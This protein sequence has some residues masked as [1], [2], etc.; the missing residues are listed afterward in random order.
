MQ[1]AA[2][3]GPALP[4]CDFRK[5]QLPVAASPC[6]SWTMPHSRCTTQARELLD[7]QSAL[8]NISVVR[9]HS[10]HALLSCL[11]ELS[12]QLGRVSWRCAW[13]GVC[14][15]TSPRRNNADACTC[16]LLPAARRPRR[17]RADPAWPYFPLTP[18]APEARC[19]LIIDSI[20]AVLAPI[21][22]PQQHQ[23]GGG[24]L[25][26]CLP[27]MQIQSWVQMRLLPL[28]AATPWTTSHLPVSRRVAVQLLLYC[29]LLHDH[30]T[31]S[32]PQA[33]FSS[34]PSRACCGT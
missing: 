21:V 13:S 17:P 33:K 11:D 9:P 12:L 2:I 1:L 8:D 4:A 19:L 10:V 7:T 27:L 26:F 20:S 25:T 32:P 5:R 34:P 6:G 23:Q 15:S 29:I 18:Q 30:S 14:S 3:S 24:G 28:L 22:G 16:L 31:V